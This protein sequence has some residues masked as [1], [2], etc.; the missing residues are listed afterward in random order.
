MEKES[1]LVIFAIKKFYQYIFSQHVTIV[2]DHKPLS[3]IVR[4][5]RNST[6]TCFKITKM[7]NYTY[8]AIIYGPSNGN[9]D[10]LSQF[11]KDCKNDFLKLEK[12]TSLTDLVES[13]VTS[14]DV[15]NE[16]AKVPFKHSNTLYSIWLANGKNF[17]LG[18]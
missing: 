17:E 8:M 3:D 11:P 7:G 12:L 13:P 4:R 6:I 15:K 1:L 2:S 5:K 9:A 16:S 18:L 14:L 10:C